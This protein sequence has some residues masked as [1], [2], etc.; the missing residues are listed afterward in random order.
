MATGVGKTT[1]MAMIITWQAL[2]ALSYS[3]RNEVFSRAVL[4]MAWPKVLRV[5]T[6]IKPKLAIDCNK[7][8]P[9]MLDPAS[10]IRRPTLRQTPSLRRADGSANAL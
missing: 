4:I 7:V 10:T 3:K 8:R 5:E 6:V 1:V 2:K 9:L